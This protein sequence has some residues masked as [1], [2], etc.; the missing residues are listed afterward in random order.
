MALAGLGQNQV[1]VV[2]APGIEGD[3]CTANPRYSRVAGPGGLVAGL[4]GV[5][6]GRFCWPVPGDLDVDGGPQVVISS[7]TGPVLGFVHREMQGLMLSPLTLASMTVPQGFMVTAL[8]QCEVWVK[9][10][11]TTQAVFG[12]KAYAKF[13]DGSIAFAAAAS[14]PNGATAS[15]YTIAAETFSA[16]LTSVVGNVLTVPATSVVTGTIYPG[17]VVSGTGITTGNTIGAQLSGTTGGAGTYSLTLTEET[18]VTV[19]TLSGTYGLLTTTTVTSGLFG[20]NQTLS[21]S[22]SPTTV[23]PGTTITAVISGSGGSGSTFAVNLTQT[24]S[25][26]TLTGA[27][28]VETSWYAQSGGL[29]GELVKI[30]NAPGVNG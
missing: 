7:G 26:G 16:T 13:A 20:V 19:G 15:A 28:Y 4:G 1:N 23:T 2:P 17:A 3:F 27:T 11:G 14:P 24:A 29:A 25:A 22:T 6:A 12:Q 21:S 10:A 8:N 30:S 9:N 18:A 5:V